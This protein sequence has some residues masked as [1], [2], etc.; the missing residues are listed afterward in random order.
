MILMLTKL[1]AMLL[2]AVNMVCAA[3]Q[4]LK[5]SIPVLRKNNLSLA[6]VIL[7]LTGILAAASIFGDTPMLIAAPM[8]TLP[9]ILSAFMPGR[10][11]R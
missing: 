8:I 5:I 7:S 1:T 10:R 3:Q 9:A 2:L 4:A 11:R 6:A